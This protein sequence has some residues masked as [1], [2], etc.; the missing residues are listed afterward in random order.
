MPQY[1]LDG[2]A[3]WLGKVFAHHPLANMKITKEGVLNAL[4]GRDVD[5]IFNLVFSMKGS[6]TDNLNLFNLHLSRENNRIIPFGSLHVENEDKKKIVDRCILEYGFYGFKLHPYVQGFSPF[7]ERLFSA[8]ER[9]EELARPINIHTGFDDYYP[10]AVTPI[11]LSGMEALIKRFSSLIFVLPHMFY[12]RLEE[13][14]YLL[15][16]YGNV[17]IDTTNIYSAIIHDEQKGVNRDNLR[18]IFRD[19]LDRYC[20]RMVFGSDYPCG[21]SDVDTIYEDFFSFKLD[22]R[23]KNEILFKTPCRIIGVELPERKG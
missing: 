11:T 15:E 6:E 20:E 23:I 21:M 13:A 22:E 12:P 9:L 19:T 18:G 7:D 2:L 14:V 10:K 16:T 17:Y 8:Y 3:Y 4:Y 5:Y 1:R